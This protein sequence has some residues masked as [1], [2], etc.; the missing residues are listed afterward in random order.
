M[1]DL[2]SSAVVGTYTPSH[3]FAGEADIV[4]E[5]FTV[6][7]GTGVCA[8]GT[9]MALLSG[10]LVKHDP[11]ALTSAATAITILTQPVDA[12]S[13][14]VKVAGYTAGF[15]NHD[16]LVWHASLTTLAARQAVFSRTPIHIGSVRL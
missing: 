15:F 9:V 6:A 4:T 3:L 7:S 10:K 11:T 14:D 16:A 1:G 2:A 13:A 8:K 12:T 5:E